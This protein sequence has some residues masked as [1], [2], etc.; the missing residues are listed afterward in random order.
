MLK[1]FQ[2]LAGN[3]PPRIAVFPDIDDVQEFTHRVAQHR[4]ILSRVP[5]FLIAHHGMTA[6]GK[7]GTA[8]EKHLELLEFLCRYAWEAA[9]DPHLAASDVVNPRA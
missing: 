1:G 8:A 5:A 9:K 3:A 4:A 2:T 7:N 6:W